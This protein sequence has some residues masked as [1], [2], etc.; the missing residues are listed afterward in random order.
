MP[1]RTQPEIYTPFSRRPTIFQYIIA[2]IISITWPT[3]WSERIILTRKS[4]CKTEGF[5]DEN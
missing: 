3:I 5:Q 1:K 2:I 4:S